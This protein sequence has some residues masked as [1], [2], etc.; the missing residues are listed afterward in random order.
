MEK[1]NLF[2]KVYRNGGYDR[3][4]FFVKLEKTGVALSASLTK[5]FK[6][7]MLGA[8]VDFPVSVVLDITK[9]D[10]F[11]KDE[12]YENENGITMVKQVV[13]LQGFREISHLELEQRTLSDF[14]VV[15][16]K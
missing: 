7:K 10:Y 16:E 5:D 13:V 12:E 8:D 2:R 11:I 15:K 9:N 4:T 6:N 1:V 3:E 14:D